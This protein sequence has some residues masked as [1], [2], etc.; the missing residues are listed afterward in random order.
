MKGHFMRFI[1]LVC[2]SFLA[3][4][5]SVDVATIK[6]APPKEENCKLDIYN[7]ASEVKRPFESLCSLGSS[8]GTTLFA[9]K[10]LQHAI[11]IARPKACECGGDAMILNQ[12]GSEG[13]SLT[14]YGKSSASINVIRYTIK[15]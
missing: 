2:F 13:M 3:A 5:A 12:V 7:N 4:C 10:S 11:D 6:D 15:K 14:G 8:T 1:N 9:D